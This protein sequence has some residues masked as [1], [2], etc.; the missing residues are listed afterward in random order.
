MAVGEIQLVRLRVLQRVRNLADWQGFRGSERHRMSNRIGPLRP[1]KAVVLAFAVAGLTALWAAPGASADQAITSSGPL[2][3][4]Y[5]NSDLSCQ[6]THTGDTHGE[7]FSGIPHGACGTFVSW[8][9]NENVYGPDVPAGNTRT[10]FHEVSQS[11][12]TGSGTTADPYKVVTTVDVEQAVA[13]AEGAQPAAVEGQVLFTVEQTDSYVVGDEFYR[14]DIKVLN[15]GIL[16]GNFAGSVYHAGDCYLQDSDYGFGWLNPSDNGIYCTQN[17]G[18]S[19]FGR[20]EGFVP[21]TAG[22]SYYEANYSDVWDAIN[23]TGVQFPNTVDTNGSGGSSEDNGA[24]LSWAFDIPSG[25]SATYSLLTRFSPTGGAPPATPTVAQQPASSCALRISRARV[26]LFTRHPRL[27]LVARY[28]TDHPADVNIDFT[29]VKGGNKDP[30]GTVTRH[31]NKHGLFRLRKQLTDDEAE[32]L[33]STD[34]FVVNFEIPG[35]P[36]FCARKYRKELTVP[37][38]IDGQRV[39][40]QSDSKFGPGS[41][42][43]PED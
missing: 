35:E 32:Q 1:H 4:I 13:S 8:P 28:R 15:N 14:S 22:S 36:G 9:S 20:I 2:D 6:A 18:N 31:F 23:D 30:L 16:D 12:V 41:P 11:P 42:G 29:A 25:G 21:I 5:L 40:F 33:Q 38:I 10:N 17:P 27:R 39:V 7:F 19:P 34:K 26:F 24:G 37:R 43:H 3:Q